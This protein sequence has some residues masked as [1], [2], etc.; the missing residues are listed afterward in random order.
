MILQAAQ[1]FVVEHIWL[2]TDRT[3]LCQVPV[4]LVSRD[5]LRIFNLSRTSLQCGQKICQRLPAQRHLEI[6]EVRTA[7]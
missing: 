6:G 5:F 4:T 7:F 2:K 1:D 3:D